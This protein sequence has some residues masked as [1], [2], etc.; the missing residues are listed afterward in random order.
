MFEKIEHCLWNDFQNC[1]TYKENLAGVS[2][3]SK[4]E[5]RSFTKDG[6][7]IFIIEE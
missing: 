4:Y 1:Y 3:P 6:F 2:K 5:I 7:I